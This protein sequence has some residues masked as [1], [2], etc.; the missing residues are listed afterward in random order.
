MKILLEAGADVNIKDNNGH[1][2]LDYARE[3]KNYAAI[4]LL[5]TSA[6]KNK[7]R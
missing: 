1:T 3:V 7:K 4:K 2:A 6:Q 5:E